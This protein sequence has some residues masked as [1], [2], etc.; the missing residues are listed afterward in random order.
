MLAYAHINL[1]SMLRRFE[2]EEAVRV[3]T[4][5]LYIRKTVLHKLEGIESYVAP[6]ICDCGEELCYECFM[7]VPF[8]PPV[9]PAQWRDKGEKLY[10]PMEHADYRAEPASVV[11]KENLPPSTAPR[12]DDPLTRHQLSYL[13]GGGGSGKTTRAIEL[14]REKN[15]LVFTPPHRLAKEM[16]ARGAKAQTY[17]PLEWPD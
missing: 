13:N 2:P 10:I 8:L 5:S 11:T 17:H 12:Y 6:R 14:F 3:A 16:R 4:D 7:G 9:A 15:P 1:L